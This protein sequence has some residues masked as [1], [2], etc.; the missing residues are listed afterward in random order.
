VEL[1]PPLQ[2]FVRFLEASRPDKHITILTT[3]GVYQQLQKFTAGNPAIS[4]KRLGRTG[5]G[6]GKMSRIVSYLSFYLGATWLLIKKR[7]A[8][9]LYYETIS[10]LPAFLFKR[11]FS[12][13]ANIM[14]HY[15]EYTSPAEYQQGM[16]LNKWFHA[17]EGWL[18]PRAGW[19]SQTNQQRMDLFLADISPIEIAR[20]EVVPNFPPLS[21]H[22]DNVAPE[23]LP[24]RFVY[25]GALAMDTMYTREMADWIL[26][27]EGR[28]TW[29]IYSYNITEEAKAY[30]HDLNS[31]WIK[32]FDGK[33]YT[34][35][36]GILCHYH[37]GVILY[38]GH[39]PN[40]VYNAPNKLFEYLN[41]G[42]KAWLPREMTG[43]LGYVD[44]VYVQAIN[45]NRLVSLELPAEGKSVARRKGAN[46]AEDA[47]AP[48]K[49]ELLKTSKE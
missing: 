13:K 35:L 49:A 28:A 27:Q 3:S 16:W 48:M 40:Y 34:A 9:V 21:W 26:Q 31:T 42:L 6:I 12:L 33:D 25:V 18:Y 5:P 1:Y 11:F 29:D 39:I 43:A 45:F 15:H 44:G 23:A 4:I 8:T 10:S 38:K 30:I 19:V 22:K 47:L 17:L 32:F 2:N 41:S 46:Y 36:P 24:V 7:P 37:I 14:I 20:P